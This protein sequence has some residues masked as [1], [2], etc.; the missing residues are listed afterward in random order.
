MRKER[1]DWPAGCQR[2]RSSLSILQ[3]TWPERTVLR[4]SVSVDELQTTAEDYIDDLSFKLYYWAN[5]KPRPVDVFNE[6]HIVAY[7][8][9]SVQ[10]TCVALLGLGTS[11]NFPVQITVNSCKDLNLPSGQTLPEVRR[12]HCDRPTI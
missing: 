6:K 8:L 7:G 3:H 10:Y 4:T 11:S 9:R 1:A 5:L 12:A 2:L